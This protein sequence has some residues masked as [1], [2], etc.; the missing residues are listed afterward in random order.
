MEDF[1]CSG[2]NIF[3]KIQAAA[4]SAYLSDRFLHT[5]PSR[6]LKSATWVPL[7]TSGISLSQS[8]SIRVV[9]ITITVVTTLKVAIF[10]DFVL[11]IYVAIIPDATHLCLR[12]NL[13]IA[14]WRETRNG[15]HCRVD[16]SHPHS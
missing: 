4:L 10:A 1:R 9:A 11:P 6:E 7:R 8:V 15:G 2:V 14:L 3:I 12:P 16:I 13:S 5:A